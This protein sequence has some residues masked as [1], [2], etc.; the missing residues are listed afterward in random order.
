MADRTESLKPDL[1][2]VRAVS[3]DVGSLP[4]PRSVLEQRGGRLPRPAGARAGGAASGTPAHAS[5]SA[6]EEDRG[7][8]FGVGPEHPELSHAIDPTEPVEQAAAGRRIGAL[9]T[10]PRGLLRS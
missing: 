2:G 3:E 5:G 1:E 9:P 10:D 6:S 4:V 7:P 8:S